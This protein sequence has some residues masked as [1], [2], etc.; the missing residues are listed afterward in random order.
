MK[1]DSRLRGNDVGD[2]RVVMGL[3]HDRVGATGRSPLR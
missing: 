1:M 3:W 2:E